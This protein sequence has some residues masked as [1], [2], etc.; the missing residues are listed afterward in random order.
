MHAHAATHLREQPAKAGA[1]ILLDSYLAGLQESQVIIGFITLQLTVAKAIGAIND[2][3]LRIRNAGLGGGRT[4]LRLARLRRTITRYAAGYRTVSR[5]IQ[6]GLAEDWDGGPTEAGLTYIRSQF[7]RAVAI[8]PVASVA[9]GTL[10][11]QERLDHD[12]DEA[13]LWLIQA[14]LVHR[15]SDVLDFGCG[16][17]RL[18]ERLSPSCR[19]V[20]GVDISRGMVEEA[21]RRCRPCANVAIRQ[22]DGG[23]LT[24]F[25]D[26]S[27]SLIAA[28]DVFPYVV[29]IGMPFAQAML[30][31]CLRVL[32][33]GGHL[34]II[35]FSYRGDTADRRDLP[36]LAT[37]T[38]FQ[39]LDG[40]A[41]EQ[42]IGGCRF[43]LQ[44][45]MTNPTSS[46][47]H[48]FPIGERRA[49]G[50]QP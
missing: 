4:L 2:R 7:D 15:G 47:I 24:P 37:A 6:A 25:S 43:L 3:Q 30:A 19:S 40:G 8:D 45:P 16:I 48:H 21:R 31:E 50:Q 11:S 18:A 41:H 36:D 49:H 28:C 42:S 33:P 46:N 32:R 23:D 22:I 27:F 5:M 26:A 14:G 10:G 44:R 1:D 35:A 13:L 38:G 9:Y 20:Q 12:S 39:V 29:Q 17:G 34:A